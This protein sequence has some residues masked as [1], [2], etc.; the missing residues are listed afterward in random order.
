MSLLAILASPVLGS[1]IGMIGQWLNRR[2]ER[3]A[4]AADYA[5]E[6]QM[7]SLR[8]SQEILVA[9]KKLQGVIEG[10]KIEVTKEWTWKNEGSMHS[11]GWVFEWSK[12]SVSA[13]LDFGRL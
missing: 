1:G 10:A 5:H 6:E 4:K 7:L 3:A 13:K 8:N 2:E 12:S 11:M 9:E